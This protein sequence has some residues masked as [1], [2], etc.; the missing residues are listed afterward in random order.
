MTSLYS[1]VFDALFA[2]LVRTILDDI[3]R[4]IALAARRAA[5][6]PV[7]L[8]AVPSLDAAVPMERLHVSALAPPLNGLV[9]DDVEVLRTMFCTEFEAAVV[10]RAINAL[11][12]L[13]A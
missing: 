11:F 5:H 13:H 3:L 6:L 7:A 2:P 9:K 8:P 1:L 12:D 10:E 4:E